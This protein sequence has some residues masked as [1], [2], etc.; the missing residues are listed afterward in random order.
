M[1]LKKINN[2][3]LTLWSFEY[4]VYMFTNLIFNGVLKESK[5]TKIREKEREIYGYT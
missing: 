5:Q 3:S 1:L 4:A 2:Q